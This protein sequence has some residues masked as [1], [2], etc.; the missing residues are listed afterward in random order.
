MSDH[1]IFGHPLASIKGGVIVTCVV[2]AF[3]STTTLWS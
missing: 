1:G 3:A 2:P